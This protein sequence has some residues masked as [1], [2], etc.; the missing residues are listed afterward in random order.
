[1]T[2]KGNE[3]DAS[4]SAFAGAARRKRKPASTID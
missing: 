2:L 4:V 1:M 3:I